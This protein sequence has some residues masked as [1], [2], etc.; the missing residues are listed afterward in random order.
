MVTKQNDYRR[1]NEKWD[2]QHEVTHWSQLTIS[3]SMC[4][5]ACV[6][7]PFLSEVPYLRNARWWMVGEQPPK[8]SS[9]RNFATSSGDSL[10]SFLCT[11]SRTRIVAAL[12][13]ITTSNC[14]NKDNVSDITSTI[15]DTL[16]SKMLSNSEISCELCVSAWSVS[17]TK[18]PPVDICENINALHLLD[19]IIKSV[20]CIALS[21][22]VKLRTWSEECDVS[23]LYS[24]S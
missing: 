19:V 4:V 9:R 13:S 10:E 3:S 12:V 21:L 22:Y 18:V 20:V 1:P 17:S 6:H 11:P 14:N 5:C 24:H 15:L 2:T 8:Q 23:T 16:L 7:M